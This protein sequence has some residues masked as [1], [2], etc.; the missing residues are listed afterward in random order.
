MAHHLATRLHELRRRSGLGLSAFA[1]ATECE[2]SCW[3]SYLAGS[4][5][6]PRR[7][8][9]QAAQLARLSAVD[10]RALLA[11]W[12]QAALEQDPA[13]C[14]SATG[15]LPPQGPRS[16]TPQWRRVAGA[17]L[18]AA[19]VVVAAGV[20]VRGATV[21]HT[22]PATAPTPT[23]TADYI[24]RYTVRD[25]MRYAGHA[26]SLTRIINSGASGQDV[27]ELQ[28]LLRDHGF[29][30]GEVDGMF[31]PNTERAVKQF[32]KA[33][34]TRSDGKVGPQTWTLLRNPNNAATSPPP[35][36]PPPTSPR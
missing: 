2:S 11:T 20:T 4:T 32:Q 24:C 27:I 23:T 33:A 34:G 15:E 30:P 29:Q 18:A 1:R 6:P 7:V 31:G 10:T 19:A 21:G 17:L 16:R 28:C 35:T 25:G 13:E 5:I 8:V 3:K 26:E 36:S 12:Q 9:E 22:A 14:H